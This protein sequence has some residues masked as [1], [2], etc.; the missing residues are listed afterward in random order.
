MNM[1][2]VVVPSFNRAKTLPYC[3]DSILA[4]TYKDIEIIIVDDGSTDNTK[5]VVKNYLQNSNVKY[6]KQENAGAQSA[7]NNGIQ[8]AKGDWIAFLDS[9][10]SWYPQKLEL[11][12]AELIK[13]KWNKYLVI[14]SN[15]FKY[16]INTGKRELFEVPH[17]EGCEVYKALLTRPAP[18]FPA[19]L[20]SK[21]ALIEIGGLDENVPAFQ[22][23]DTSIR[24]AKICEFVHMKIPL[25]DY[26]FHSGETISK[27]STNHILGYQ[28]ILEKFKDEI[29]NHCGVSI[30]KRHLQIQHRSFISFKIFDSDMLQDKRL[31]NVLSTIYGE[32][33]ISAVTPPE[34]MLSLI[35]KVIK[36]FLLLFVNKN[37]FNFTIKCFL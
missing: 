15:C 19:M 16:E 22:E 31:R 5:C 17:T 32:I 25:F 28:Y 10:D 33:K 11:Q 3:L 34:K 24:L 2:S 13:R 27:S 30:W 4:Q 37:N 20:T 14:H 12:T 26:Y 23:W 8:L 1:I 18:F 35:R 36:S 9:D 29:I 21:K 6:F 7:R